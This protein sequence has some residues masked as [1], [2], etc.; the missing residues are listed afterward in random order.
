MRPFRLV[1]GL[2][3]VAC[4]VPLLADATPPVSA[5]PPVPDVPPAPARVAPPPPPATLPPG[6]A[7]VRECYP[8]PLPEPVYGGG[9][10]GYGGGYGGGAAKTSAGF[11]GP[12][13]AAPPPAAVPTARTTRARSEAAPVEEAEAPPA[14]DAAYDLGG[15]V[16][17]EPAVERSVRQPVPLPTPPAVGPRVDWGGVVHLSNDDSMSLA[18]A[19]RLLWALEHDAPFAVDQ[20]RPH[21]LLNYFTFDP[22]PPRPGDVFGMTASAERTGPDELALALTVEAV[23]P[24]RAPL[25]LTVLV[26]RSGSMSA[27]GRMDYTKRALARLGEQLKRGDRLDLVLFDDE[28][29]TPLE[30][31]VVGRDDPALLRRAVEE[32]QPRNSTDLD[33]GLR[34]AYRVASTHVGLPGRAPRVMVFTDALLNTG[35]VNPDTV[36]EIGRAMEQHG[37]RLTGVGVGSEFRDDVLDALT[38]K[39]HGAYVFLGSERVVDRLFGRGFDALVQTVAED[40]R[41]AL[42]LPPSLGMQKFYGEEAS[43]VAEDV[44]PVSFHAGSRQVFLQDLAIRPGTLRNDDALKLTVSWTDP[45]DGRR[46]EQVLARTVGEALAA[47]PHTVRKARALIGWTD[48]LLAHALGHDACGAPFGEYRRR[49]GGVAGD[50]EIAYATELLGRWCDTSEPVA[51]WTEPARAATKVRLDA[52]V[53]VDEVALSCGGATQRHPLTGSDTVARFETVPGSC[54]VTLFGTVPMTAR[55][56]VPPTGGDVRCVLRGGRL[57]CR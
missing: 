21:E 1:L 25:D 49:I 22:A 39:G 54:L 35:D 56:D 24:P 6:H 27:E 47:D 19:Q 15:A 8:R 3:A 52:D 36:T 53:P 10:G 38:E 41:F 42:A 14:P 32:L 12:V 34:E 33:L 29:C 16:I 50:A 9:R 37:V 48:V 17:Q 30:D 55:V 57:D 11:G 13:G 26:D 18:S 4:A 40:V 31:F 45:V 5:A 43:R 44:Q 28:V 23:T 46:R 51:A 20:V 2:A 7:I